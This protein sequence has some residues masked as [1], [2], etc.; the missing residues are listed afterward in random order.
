M[1]KKEGFLAEAFFYCLTFI[2]LDRTGL[3]SMLNIILVLNNDINYYML[4][5]RA[6]WL[7]FRPSGQIRYFTFP[8]ATMN[9]LL[10]Q[11][12]IR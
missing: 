8:G 6:V 4:C 5:K 12:L 3:Y 1:Q 9:S 7:S 10:S 2:E 11:L